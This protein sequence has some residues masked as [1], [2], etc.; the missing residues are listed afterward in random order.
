MPIIEA[1]SVGRPIVVSNLCSLPEVAG[2]AAL[3]I[4]PENSTE[5][6]MAIISLIED[7]KKRI[8]LVQRGLK[9]IKRFTLPKI[10]NEYFE[11]YK[12]VLPNL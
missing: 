10:A 11:L 7:E 1:N 9:N 5:I 4:N 6:R 12:S 3:F 2:N 8:L